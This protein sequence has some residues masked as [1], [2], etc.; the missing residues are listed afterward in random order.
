[1]HNNGWCMCW[2][3]RLKALPALLRSS[4]VIFVDGYGGTY[5]RLMVLPLSI[6]SLYRGNRAYSLWYAVTRGRF[7]LTQACQRLADEG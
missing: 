5:Q 4:T 3:C 1:M 2:R 6:F 7:A